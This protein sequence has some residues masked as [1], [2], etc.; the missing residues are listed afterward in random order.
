MDALRKLD[1]NVELA[2]H[3]GVIQMSVLCVGGIRLTF[4][5]S[6]RDALLPLFCLD[7]STCCLLFRLDHSDICLLFPAQVLGAAV[8]RGGRA[9][10][11]S[12]G[13]EATAD[14]EDT[15]NYLP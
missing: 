3:D 2:K 14:K 1:S 5:T 7:P 15:G 12:L 8:R 13:L 9:P 6:G 10:L 4:Q 11:S